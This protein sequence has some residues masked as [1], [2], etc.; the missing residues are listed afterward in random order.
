MKLRTVKTAL[1]KHLEVRLKG[2]DAQRLESLKIR[3]LIHRAPLYTHTSPLCACK[4][5]CS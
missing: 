3:G 5:T 4:H 2:R 1:E